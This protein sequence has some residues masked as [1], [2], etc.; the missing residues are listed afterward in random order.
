MVTCAAVDLCS[1]SLLV[2]VWQTVRLGSMLHLYVFVCTLTYL[3]FKNKREWGPLLLRVDR[4][5]E[6]HGPLERRGLSSGTTSLGTE[7]DGQ[8]W[9]QWDSGVVPTVGSWLRGDQQKGKWKSISVIVVFSIKTLDYPEQWQIQ[10]FWHLKW[11]SQCSSRMSAK[12]QK[13]KYKKQ[14]GKG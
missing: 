13:L 11:K 4:W 3:R 6:P 12:G 9:L 7:G 5:K 2:R 14:R 10:S 1:C 8:C